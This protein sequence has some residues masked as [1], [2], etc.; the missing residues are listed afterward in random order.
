MI[1]EHV[2]KPLADELLFGRLAKGGV[3]QM[4]IADGEPV[5]TYPAG[6]GSAKSGKGRPRKGG[7]SSKGT[8]ALVE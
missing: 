4:D 8:P 2:K 3:V 1:Q 7:K 6:D 5:F